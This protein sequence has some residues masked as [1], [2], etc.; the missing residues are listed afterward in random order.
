MLKQL[1]IKFVIINMT[2]V[3]VMLLVILGLIIYQTQ[4]NLENQSIGMMQSVSADPFRPGRPGGKPDDVR[5]P[6]FEVFLSK[7]NE[8]VAVKGGFFDLSDEEQVQGIVLA[9]LDNPETVGVLSEHNMR[10]YKIDNRDVSRIVFADMSSEQATMAN[11]IRT[12][13]LIGA[14]SFAAFLFISFRLAKWAVKPVDEAWQQQKQFV[15]DASHELK[16]PLTVIMTNAEL[17]QNPEYDEPAKEQF[18]SSI[19]IMSHQMRGLVEGLLDLARVDNGAVQTALAPVC[20]SALTEEACLIFEPLFFE[21]NLFLES[22]VEPGLELRGSE[23]HLQQVLKILLDNAMKY[24]ESGSVTVTL[25]KQGSGCLLTVANPGPAISPAD[26][27]NIFKRFYRVDKSRHRDGSYGLGL[28][29]AQNIVQEHQGR[30]WAESASGQNRFHVYLP[31][32]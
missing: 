6:Y 10:F 18:A 20:L 17:L 11:L 26:L 12:C 19:L 23:T 22:L 3:T 9:A 21:R 28:S 5:L 29:I 32:T 16:T 25:Q 4:K 14:V 8:V 2:L 24:S 7:E 1:R 13:M 31:I 30:I 15:A 27:K